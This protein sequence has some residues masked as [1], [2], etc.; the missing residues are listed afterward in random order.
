MNCRSTLPQLP[1]WA[2]PGMPLA[3]A[4]GYCI[5]QAVTPLSQLQSGNSLIRGG[6][7]QLPKSSQVAILPS[8]PIRL[9]CLP[10]LGS[11]G[12]GEIGMCLTGMATEESGSNPEPPSMSDVSCDYSKRNVLLPDPAFPTH[13]LSTA[14]KRRSM[15]CVLP[16]SH[17]PAI[18]LEHQP[19]TGTLQPPQ[20]CHTKSL[21]GP[22]RDTS[23]RCLIRKAC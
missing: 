23:Q 4:A 3:A 17:P 13:P 21:Q 2:V 15:C 12:S 14:L 5:P 16:R 20:L 18:P 22:H 11:G 1:S 19:F 6:Q 10:S 8:L 7:K 9:A